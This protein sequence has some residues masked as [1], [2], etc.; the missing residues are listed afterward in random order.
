MEQAES[1]VKAKLVKEYMSQF[2]SNEERL[3]ELKLLMRGEE[4]GVS[5][6]LESRPANAGLPSPQEM[7][8][9]LL[10]GVSA[11]LEIP[12]SPVMN[13]LGGKEGEERKAKELGKEK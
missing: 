8:Q 7:H 3:E 10:K 13:P 5:Q 6:F 2:Q 1:N 4:S 11:A 9:A 12:E